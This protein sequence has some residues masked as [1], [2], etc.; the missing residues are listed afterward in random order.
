[1]NRKVT[2][3]FTLMVTAL[4]LIA[5]AQPVFSAS[6]S[7]DKV[8]TSAKDKAKDKAKSKGKTTTK[9]KEKAKSKVKD[10]AKDKKKAAE[11]KFTGKKVNINSADAKTLM[12]LK[13]IGEKKAKAILD[14]RK[15]N[16]KFKSLADLKNVPGIGDKIYKT[17]SSSI[18]L[19]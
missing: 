16:G 10:K 9:E 7:K 8:T 5:F 4:C 13:G 3:I 19:K 12:S 6:T 18:S 11:K 1:M 14:Y 17:I 15:K 2:Q